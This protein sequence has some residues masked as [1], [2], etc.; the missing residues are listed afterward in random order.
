MM[1][2]S[3]ALPPLTAKSSHVHGLILFSSK[4]PTI[5]FCV[6][7]HSSGPCSFP[8]SELNLIL[9][10][11]KSPLTFVTRFSGLPQAL[12]LVLAH[13]TLEGYVCLSFHVVAIVIP[14]FS[15]EEN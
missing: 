10:F 9:L 1:S 4:V 5:P 15:E 2:S 3:N 12:V 11:G 13:N 7:Q 8:S 6:S 14:C